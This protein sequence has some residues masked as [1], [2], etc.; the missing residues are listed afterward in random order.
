[1]AKVVICPSCQSKA[2]IPDDAQP[3]RIRCPKC[4]QTFDTGTASKSS[5]GQA[6]R[7][8]SAKRPPAAVSSAYDK[9][10]S[11]QPLPTLSSSSTSRRAA[12]AAAHH[13]S[14]QSPIMYAVLGVGGLAIVLLLVVLVVVLTR[15]SGDP[16]AQARQAEVV[17]SD[18]PA[19]AI[20]P[21]AAVTPIALVASSVE[22][23]PA[24]SSASP[25]PDSDQIMSRLKDATVYLKHKVAGRTLSSGTGFVIEV[26]G[27]TVVLATNRH[28][29]VFDVSD[30]PPSLV[31]KDSKVEFE[32]VFRSG[33]GPQKEQAL[34]AQIVV[35]DTSGDFQTDLAILAVQGVKKPPAPI[36]VFAKSETTE[37]MA[38]AAA[39]F[40]FGGLLNSASSD[41]KS[42][43]TVT[44]PF[45]HISRRILD[46]DGQLE[47]FQVDGSLQPG[48]SGGPIVEEKTGKLIGLAVAKLGSVDTIG[49]VIPA[50]ELRRMLAGRVG[51]LNL[52]LKTL[53][54]KNANLEITAQ[55]VD[56]KGNVKDVLVHA[57]P[58]SAGTVSPNADGSYPPLPNTTG[59]GLQRA[60]KVAMASGQV[61]VALSGEGAAA[62]KI[63]VQTAHRDTRGKVVYS[64]PREIELPEK[65]GPITAPGQLQR[66]I[67]SVRRKSFTMLEKLIDPDKDCKLVK[68]DD[69][70]KFTIEIP[71]DKVHTLAPELVTRRNKKK[72][73]HNAPLAL[74]EVEG[75]FLAMVKVTGEISAGSK[76]PKDKQGNND[77]IFFT[78]QGA[79]LIIYQDTDNFMRLERAS[80][81]DPRNL[82]GYHKLLIEA[83]R[84]GRQAMA[85]IYMPFPDKD[86]L[87]V[88]IKR[89]GKVRCLFSPDDGNTVV[90]MHEFELDLPKKSKV[91]LV[92]SNIS[93][94]PFSATFEDFAILND[95]TLIDAQFGDGESP[96]NKK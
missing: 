2:S 91:G 94:R 81:V 67:K 47:L 29:A 90:A 62:R 56:P 40:P 33:Q 58:A 17:H 3:A 19:A 79:G 48:N 13:Y 74:T 72:P 80:G 22:S 71:G 20:E 84:D 35:A 27:D 95:T 23:A 4:K 37:G 96:G 36:S 64:K 75:D 45:G 42:N 88:L 92:A 34:P 85:Q 21:A 61:Q 59:V 54:P 82:Q 60:P 78:F 50:D 93:A 31:P 55:I 39:G 70:M 8:A 49:L 1:V 65:P 87:L 86:S 24:G 5:A 46:K 73:L 16:P 89:K 12:G 57:A 63:L 51:A 7:P 30:V 10:Q 15:G 52:T 43:P 53:D 32:A 83:V 14:G 44:T 66:M 77:L 69:R 26:R 76:V 38:Y 28:V 41:R 11:V 6:K 68:D 18:P 9:I 25:V